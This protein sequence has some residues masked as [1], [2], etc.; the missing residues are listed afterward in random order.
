MFT[1]LKV[2]MSKKLQEI[3]KSLNYSVHSAEFCEGA[4]RAIMAMEDF[5]CINIFALR[6][7]YSVSKVNFCDTVPSKGIAEALV[8]T[9]S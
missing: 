3:I 1:Q 6:G 2:T 5:F 9:K 4:I 8:L 7:Y